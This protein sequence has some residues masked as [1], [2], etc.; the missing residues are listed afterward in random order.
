MPCLIPN[1]ASWQ[2]V[3]LEDPLGANG[4]D[5]GWNVFQ[6]DAVPG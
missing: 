6:P 1:A 2:L 5:A 4:H 3:G